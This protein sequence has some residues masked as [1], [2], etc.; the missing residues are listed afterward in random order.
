MTSR[1]CF[2]LSMTLG[3]GCGYA[4]GKTRMTPTLR[5][6]V[7]CGA[8]VVL[9][10]VVL[11]AR[12]VLFVAT[13]QAHGAYVGFDFADGAKYL[14]GTLALAIVACVAI[15]FL[16][17]HFATTHAPSASASL[18]G[19]VAAGTMAWTLAAGYWEATG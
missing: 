5:D 17:A 16:I 18:I 10:L 7:A 3:A 13:H 4:I 19:A 1:L 2:L 8:G 15:H 12:A 14:S 11:T 9:S 6:V